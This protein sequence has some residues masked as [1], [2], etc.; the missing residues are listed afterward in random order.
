MGGKTRFVPYPMTWDDAPVDISFVFKK[1]A[2]AGKHGFLKVKDGKFIFEDGTRAKFWGTNFNSAANFPPFEYSEKVAKRLA[3][4]GIN[5]V[6]FHQMDSEWSTPNIFQFTKGERKGNTLNLDPESLKRLDYLVY[7]LKKEG[8][9]IYIDMMTYRKFK[10][11]DGVAAAPELGDAAKPYGNFDRR[12]I[13]LQKKYCYDLWTHINPYTGLMYKDDPVFVLTEIVNESDLFLPER[14]PVKLEPYRTELEK[15]FREWA[16]RRNIKLGEEKV[17]FTCHDETMLKFLCDVQMDYYREMIAFLRKIGVKIPIAG[18]N[19]SINAANRYTQLVTDFTD[20]HVYWYAWKWGEIQK[21]FDNRPMVGEVDTIFPELS[22]SRFLD[23]PYFVSEWDD[24][25]P[26]EWRAESPVFL[27]A[28]GALQ[29]WDGFAI[30]TYRYSNSTN[31]DLIG[32]EIA[33]SAIGGVPYREGIFNTYNDPAKFGLFY[34]SALLFRRGDVRPAKKSMA[35]KIE[36]MSLRPSTT[37]AMS[38][39]TEK[40]RVGLKFEGQKSTADETIPWDSPAVD[41]SAGEITSD[42][43]ELYRSW[44]RKFGWI[45]SERTKAVYGFLGSAGKIS[46]NG[47]ELEVRNDFA[48]IAISSLTDAPIGESDNM[49]LTTAGRAENTDIKYNESHTAMLDFG[50]APILIEAIEAKFRIKT[51]IPGLKVW[52]VG[53]EGFYTAEIPSTCRDGYLVFKTGEKYPSL[54][55]LIQAE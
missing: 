33:A 8:I 27:A 6:R 19:W 39:I 25:W 16:A 29:D 13:E 18:T 43:R 32:K 40:H 37:P 50:H 21:E 38:L 3:K 5:I 7:C 52:A 45:D 15:R 9:Y 20:G 48:S 22:F 54:Y 1:E 26:N 4:F 10:S 46:L 41:K 42:T 17:D 11:G 49:L 30:H 47:L 34:H 2:P 35:V 53:P 31:M 23:R 51:E 44:T 36:D 55:Y 14:N 28:V 24:P 12:L